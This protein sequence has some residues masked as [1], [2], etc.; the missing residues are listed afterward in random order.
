LIRGFATG[1]RPF[2][3]LGIQQVAVGG[4]DKNV[5]TK[6]WVDQLGVKKVGQYKSEVRLI[7]LWSLVSY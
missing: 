2:R 5:L 4:L 7:H 1:T 3:I 6:F